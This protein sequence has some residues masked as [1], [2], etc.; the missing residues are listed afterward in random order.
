MSIPKDSAS[1]SQNVHAVGTLAPE[2]SL[3]NYAWRAYLVFQ[4]MLRPLG[5]GLNLGS[6]ALQVSS[7]LRLETKISVQEIDDAGHTKLCCTTRH[8]VPDTSLAEKHV[9]RDQN[10]VQLPYQTWTPSSYICTK[11]SNLHAVT[12]NHHLVIMSC[13]PFVPQVVGQQLMWS[14][15]NR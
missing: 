9:V 6:L 14:W 13:L 7:F 10:R 3:P 2:S 15:L 5:V 12:S 1:R 4:S 11:P 8:I